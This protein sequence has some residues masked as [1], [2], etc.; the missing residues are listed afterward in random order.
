[1]ACL[2]SRSFNCSIRYD[3]YCD[4]TLLHCLENSC[5]SFSFAKEH[6]SMFSLC[7]CRGIYLI[8]QLRIEHFLFLYF[9]FEWSSDFLGIGYSISVAEDKGSKMIY[10]GARF[11]HPHNVI[12]SCIISQPLK[13]SEWTLSAFPTNVPQLL[14][15]GSCIQES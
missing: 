2:G 7:A 10:L 4:G 3:M 6:A 8:P 1:M 14:L 9:T 11:V 13:S 15:T 12:Y 5:V